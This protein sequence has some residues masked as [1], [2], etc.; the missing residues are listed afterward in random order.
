MGLH[1]QPVSH[2]RTHAGT[3]PPVHAYAHM[4]AHAATRRTHAHAS[5]H[6]PLQ[7][8]VVGFCAVQLNRC[9]VGDATNENSS[10][11]YADSTSCPRALYTNMITAAVAYWFPSPYMSFLSF[12]NSELATPRKRT[13]KGTSQPV[14]VEEEK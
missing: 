11:G 10:S 8:H 4:H 7:A 14:P 13:T 2:T 9:P 6:T 12:G 1:L 5:P 3:R